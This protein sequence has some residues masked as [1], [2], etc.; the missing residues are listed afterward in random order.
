M[1]ATELHLRRADPVGGVSPSLANL[2]RCVPAI[3]WMEVDALQGSAHTGLP[4]D[5]F[6]ITV[7]CS[8]GLRCGPLGEA[9]ELEVMVTS[10]RTRPARFQSLGQGQLAVALLTPLGAMKVLRAPLRDITDRRVPLEQLCGRAEQRRLHG[11]LMS[12]P[13][14][15]QRMQVFGRW[16]ESRVLERHVMSVAQ[17]RVAEASAVLQQPPSTPHDFSAL[18]SSLAVTRRQLERDFR[19]W[20]GMPPAGYARLVRFQQ[21]AA[22]V[23][24]GTP[25]VHVAID[26]GFADQA[27]L[28]RTMRQLAGA[29]PMAMRLDAAKPGRAAARSALAGRVLMLDLAHASTGAVAANASEASN[30]CADDWLLEAA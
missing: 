7:Y 28:T 30:V 24:Q 20:M 11:L 18:A 17:S 23:A 15:A 25:L 5:L 12:A 3:G 6:L 21:A 9:H 13:T 16:L 27:H 29:T 4:S 8:D 22:A 1:F 10:L 14:N 19:E 26:C 2:A